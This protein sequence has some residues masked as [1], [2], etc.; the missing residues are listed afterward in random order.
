[1]HYSL[2]PLKITKEFEFICPP[3]YKGA[4]WAPYVSVF[5]HCAGVC[6]RLLTLA[7]TSNTFCLINFALNMKMHPELQPRPLVP[8]IDVCAY[9]KHYLCNMRVWQHTQRK[10]RGERVAAWISGRGGLSRCMRLSDVC[11]LRGT[12]SLECNSRSEPLW[13]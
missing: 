11:N 4:A 9:Y 6:L 5:L 2:Q 7:R 1:M 12:F 3:Q 10:M 13:W 8:R